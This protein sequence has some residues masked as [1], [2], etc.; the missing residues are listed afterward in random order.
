[1]SKDSLNRAR[2]S[3]EQQTLARANMAEEFRIRDQ[4]KA[5]AKEAYEALLKLIAQE[6][7]T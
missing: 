6:T 2:W 4:E 7:R 3:R 5:A 1:M